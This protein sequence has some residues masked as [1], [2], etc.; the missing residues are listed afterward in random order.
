MPNVRIRKVSTEEEL[1]NKVDDYQ[2]QG[3][4]VSEQSDKHVRVRKNS[5]GSGF[6]HF[7]WFILTVWFT[8]GLG[9]LGYAIYAYVSNSDEVVVQV[10]NK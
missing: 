6:V 2:I 7:I 5:Y 1:H 3:Y 9:N 8:F 10:K 4:S